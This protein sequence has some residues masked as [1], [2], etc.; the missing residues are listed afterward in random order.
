MMRTTS[1]NL[2]VFCLISI[3]MASVAGQPCRSFRVAKVKSIFAIAPS[4][5]GSNVLFYGSEEESEGEIITGHLFRL[6]LDRADGAMNLK[7]PDA[8]NPSPPVWRPDGDT[9]YFGTD[10]GIYQ[11]SANG[12]APPEL[13]WKGSPSGLAISPDGVFL[14]FWHVEKGTDTLVVYDLKKKSEAHTWQLPDR[15]EGDKSS[16]DVVFER[17]GRALY[18]RTYDQPSDTPLRRFDLETGKIAIVSSNCYAAAAGKDGV[19]FIEALGEARSLHKITSDHHP[20]LVAGS[21]AYDSLNSDGN[22]RWLISQDYRTRK[23]V[24]LDSETDAIKPIGKHE[25][26]TILPDGKL[27]LVNGAEI[28]VSDSSCRTDKQTAGRTSRD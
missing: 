9:A 26:G 17:D 27:L 8:S 22:Q 1:A 28:V 11:V 5:V 10:D 15:F 24:L 13:L 18:A 12:D 3:V 23:M 2:S 19:Y 21:F 6:R 7:A 4:P 25:A 16:W 20:T 14:S